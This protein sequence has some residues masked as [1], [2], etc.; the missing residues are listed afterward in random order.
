MCVII[1]VNIILNYTVV[2]MMK[3]LLKGFNAFAGFQNFIIS[4]APDDGIIPYPPNTQCIIWGRD[5]SFEYLLDGLIQTILDCQEVEVLN[6]RII[7]WYD[8]KT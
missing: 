1:L 8:M 4:W 7:C 2:M 3:L 6:G 5:K